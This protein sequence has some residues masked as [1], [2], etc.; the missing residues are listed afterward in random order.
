M[1]GGPLP[2]ALF[3]VHFCSQ[4]LARDRPFGNVWHMFPP[5]GGFIINQDEEGTFTAHMALDSLDQDTSKI[6][7]Y[8]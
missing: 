1:L 2:I 3:L 7:P 6:D 8:K 4:E 5:F